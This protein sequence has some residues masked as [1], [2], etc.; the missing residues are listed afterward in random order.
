MHLL[1]RYNVEK[2]TE[3]LRNKVIKSFTE[4][5]CNYNVK[6]IL[7]NNDQLVRVRAYKSWESFAGFNVTYNCRRCR[8]LVKGL[9]LS[10]IFSVNAFNKTE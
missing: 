7:H 5:I 4:A 6:T 1:P 3:S 8:F 9:F 10:K 2:R